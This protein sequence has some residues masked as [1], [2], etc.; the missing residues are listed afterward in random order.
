MRYDRLLEPVTEQEPCGPDLDEIGDEKYLNYVLPAASRVPERFYKADTDK[1]IERSEIK[2]KAEVEEIAALLEASRDIRLLC[3]EARFQSFAGDLP[4]F[5]DCIQAIAGLVERFWED[6][7]PKSSEGDFTLRQNVLSGLDD[8]WQIIH[9]LQHLPLVRDKRLGPV[10]FRHFAVASGA[11]QKRAD[12][13]P[14]DLSDIY[15]ALSAE[16]NR[17]ASDASI[18]AITRTEQALASIRNSFIANAGYDYVPSFDKLSDF[19]SKAVALF[20][21]ARPDLQLG[22][23][24]SDEPGEGEA[25]GADATINGAQP[26]AAASRDPA[27]AG[28]IATHAD[29]TAALLAVE[30][31]F[32]SREP[33][34]PAL[35]LVHQA[36]MLVGKPLVYA[37]EALV[38]EAAAKAVIKFQSGIAFQ[39]AMPAMKNLTDTVTKSEPAQG[40]TPVSGGVYVAQS[41]SEAMA[42]IAEVE[43][44]FKTAEPSSPIPMLLAKANGFTNRNFDMIL[45]DLIGPTT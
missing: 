1:P 40:V 16:E 19:L 39:L 2:L 42:L 28:T 13:T 31:Y 36:R 3:I 34:S 23:S 9:P 17:E 29:A 26:A 35:I 11:A 24:G 12:E 27:Y 30:A 7:H 33:S 37:I 8:W 25:S 45:K 22:A 21:V 5:A 18:A 4:G 44:F 15:R 14:V 32:A 43:L 6:V 20:G 41:R 10:T 38:P